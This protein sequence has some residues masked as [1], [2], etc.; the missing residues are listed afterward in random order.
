MSGAAERRR[1]RL[2]FLGSP[3]FAVPTL[4]ALHAAGHEV[5]AVYCQPPR[6]AGRG[7]REARCPVHRVADGELGLPVRTPARL[8]NNAEEHAVF[9]SKDPIWSPRPRG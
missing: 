8:R 9:A 2:A 7:K 5:A 4:R 6:P 1:L 3:E